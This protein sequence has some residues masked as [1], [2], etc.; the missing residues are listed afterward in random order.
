MYALKIH[1]LNFQ[2]F[3]EMQTDPSLDQQILLST[4]IDALSS[5]C[6]TNLYF[7]NVCS[8]KKFWE[9]YYSQHGL[10][11]LRE[12]TT[13]EEYL[14]DFMVA[15]RVLDMV[16]RIVLILEFDQLLQ[17][18]LYEPTDFSV[19][20][21]NNSEL[22]AFI[23]KGRYANRNELSLPIEDRDEF[24]FQS[25]PTVTFRYREDSKLYLIR[26][27]MTGENRV[28]LKLRYNLSKESLQTIL[29]KLIFRGS[30]FQWIT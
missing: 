23:A 15:Q 6:V 7:R 25:N 22:L 29:Y 2:I 30:T 27:L 21:I 24:S 20:E 9:E 1:F 11:L 10:L 19:Q 3:K 26:F 17:T 12:Y 13:A 14:Q 16:D 4:D 8:I 28:N 5:I 18:D